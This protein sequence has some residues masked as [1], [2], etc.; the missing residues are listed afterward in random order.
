LF[1]YIDYLLPIVFKYTNIEDLVR[2]FGSYDG[3]IL[4]YSKSNS[5]QLCYEY[6][7]LMRKEESYRPIQLLQGSND[8]K[9][10][11]EIIATEARKHFSDDI[12]K[13]YKIIHTTD[14][15]CPIGTV[16]KFENRFPKK[17][18]MILSGASTIK[19]GRLFDSSMEENSGLQMTSTLN[20]NSKQFDQHSA[21][22]EKILSLVFQ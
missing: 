12:N 14:L 21:I 16:Y 6:S 5:L 3:V 20:H 1:L 19:T 10:H 22:G 2:N 13:G 8:Q 15:L 9:G 7:N 17:F 4:C 18:E 11:G